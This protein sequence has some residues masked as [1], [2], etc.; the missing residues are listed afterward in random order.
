DQY[1]SPGSG[2]TYNY[3]DEISLSPPAGAVYANIELLYQP[4]SWEY[5]QFL[6]LANN[7]QNPLLGSE[8]VNLLEAWLNTGMAEPYV[9]VSTVWGSAPTPPTPKVGVTN[10]V[11]KS[12]DKRGNIG[13]I[14]DVFNQGD[15]VAIVASIVDEN[16]ITLSGAQ[17]FLEIRDEGNNLIRTLQGFSDATGKAVITWKTAR[18]EAV[19]VYTTK[20][21]DIIIS[22]YEFDLNQ[23]MVQFAIQ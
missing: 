19:G 8:G 1:G 13:P 12:V 22:G 16:S 11:T 20:V 3:W 9:M 23:T 6:Y 17:V 18:K 10:L 4:T 7:E 21:V 5:I 2:G 15:T 14:N